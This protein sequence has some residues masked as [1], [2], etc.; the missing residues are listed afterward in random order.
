MRE[1]GLLA[2]EHR[3]TG[4]LGYEAY[5]P[6][7]EDGTCF[8]ARWW[9][10]MFAYLIQ[11]LRAIPY[12]IPAVTATATACI[13]GRPASIQSPGHR[14]RI[15][16]YPLRLGSEPHPEFQVC[17]LFWLMVADRCSSSGVSNP[18]RP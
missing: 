14:R 2:G 11:H 9:R 10:G 3:L 7:L 4:A 1:S 8:N 17:G 5:Q 15:R 18:K 16:R 6:K 12:D 13:A